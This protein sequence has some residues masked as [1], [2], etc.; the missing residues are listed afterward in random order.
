MGSTELSQQTPCMSKSNSY[1]K[2][3]SKY[4]QYKVY[5]ASCKQKKLPEDVSNVSCV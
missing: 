5:N 4:K 3:T 2:L 1:N